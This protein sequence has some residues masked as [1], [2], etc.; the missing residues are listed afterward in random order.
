[1]LPEASIHAEAGPKFSLVVVERL[2]GVTRKRLRAVVEQM[3]GEL[4]SRPSLQLDV[5]A[6]AHSSASAVLRD[7]PRLT[8]PKGIGPAARVISELALKRMLGLARPAAEEDRTLD[9]ADLMRASRLPADVIA[10]L[11]AYDVV[12]PVEGEFAS[13]DLLVAREVGRLLGRGYDLATTVTAAVTLRRSRAS[14]SQVRLVEA[15]WGD[16][17]QQVGDMFASLEGQLA[18]P[19]PHEGGS[20]DDLFERAEVAEASGDPVSAERCYRAALALDRSDPT[21]SY[22]LANVLA[23]QGRRNDAVLAYYE[24]LKRA[25]DFAEAWF[26]L[27]VIE[28]EEGRVADAM[29]NYRRALSAQPQFADALFNLALLLTDQENYREAASVWERF[30]RLNPQGP[31]RAKAKR[32]ATLCRIAQAT[33]LDAPSASTQTGRP[34]LGSPEQPMLF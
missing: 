13:R 10:C 23:E 31:D 29:K 33:S 14:L 2:H 28:E 6:L 8:L 19:L 21:L 3:G 20:V 24:A 16:I 11:A 1:M 30:L 15:P 26:N 7:A 4:A 12:E 32:Y 9:E 25:P 5:V 27:G 34:A 22:N 18:L 17:V